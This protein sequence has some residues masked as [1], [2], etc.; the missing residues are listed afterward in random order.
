MQSWLKLTQLQHHIKQ[1][2]NKGMFCTSTKEVPL[3]H[4]TSPHTSPLWMGS[5]EQSLFNISSHVSSVDRIR[6]ASP[7]STSPHTSPLWIG[8]GERVR[9][10]HT[11]SEQ[12]VSLA[13]NFPVADLA[14]HKRAAS[15]KPHLRRVYPKLILIPGSAETWAHMHESRITKHCRWQVCG[16]LQGEE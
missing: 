3:L 14:L 10:Q 8:S 1:A 9:L 7:P 4:S 12:D 13:I 11:L 6:R 5:G 16:T 2:T 15:S